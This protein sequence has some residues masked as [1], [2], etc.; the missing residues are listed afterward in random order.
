MNNS[1]DKE[2]I[3]RTTLSKL[4]EELLCLL[5][6]WYELVNIQQPRLEFMYESIFGDLE[7]ELEQKSRAANEL[8][9]RVE[10][11]SWKLKKGER[12]N[13]ST[14]EFV[15]MM[16]NR[17]FGEDSIFNR[18]D[19]VESS[20]QFNSNQ[21]S[22]YYHHTRDNNL[23]PEDIPA[24]YRA[25]VKKLHPDIAG[26]S[27]N[28]KRFWN[29]IQAAYKERDLQRL[30]L[31]KQTLCPEI[32]IEANDE[33]KLLQEVRELES[34]VSKE[35]QKI[36]KLHQQ[37]PF[38]LEEKLNDR[39]WILRRK[40]ALRDR[41]FQMDRKISFNH[42]II[43]SLTA[44]IENSNKPKSHPSTSSY[45]NDRPSYGFRPAYSA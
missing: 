28:Y 33:V 43:N 16:I 17:E 22:N 2:I 41:L 11:L 25:L 9:R 29:N 27:D 45:F 3:L 10:L 18:K 19:D 4:K 14:V 32:E 44:G 24:I 7:I 23:K 30:I 39:S 40:K 15:E 36:R 37:E 12:I 6:D 31:F 35:R 20:Q 42:K 5:D 8:D 21:S 34:L 13:K 38:V 1:N 26:E